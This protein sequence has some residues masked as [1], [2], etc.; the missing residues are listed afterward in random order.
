MKV[1]KAKRI[2]LSVL[3]MLIAVVMIT[4]AMYAVEPRYQDLRVAHCDLTIDEGIARCYLYV[5]GISL[6]NRYDV[7]LVLYQ[8]EEDYAE[9][10]ASGTMMVNI[11]ET[12]YVTQD[13]E[14]YLGFHIKVYDP[15]GNFIEQIIDYTTPYYYE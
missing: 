11:N 6:Y 10:E 8:D 3:S 12:C 5:D 14:Y 2:V 15:D 13:H 7:R 1:N 9:W 4:P